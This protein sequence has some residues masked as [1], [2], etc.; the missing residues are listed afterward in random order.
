VSAATSPDMERHRGWLAD[1]LQRLDEADRSEC[2]SRLRTPEQY[3]QTTAELA[4][5][6]V[7][8]GAGL[9]V[10]QNPR[11]GHLTPDV[12]ATD[13][14]GNRI[15]FEVWTRTIPQETVVRLR[16]WGALAQV[17][18]KV[19]VPVLLA[20]DSD[21]RSASDPPL[22]GEVSVI[23]KSLGRWL[24]SGE[25]LAR[26]SLA[27]AG[28]IFTDYGRYDGDSAVLLPVTLATHAD[29]RHV[30][31]AVNN[32]VRRYRKLAME[33]SVPFVVVL[34]AEP[35]SGLDYD[36]VASALSGRNSLTLNFDVRTFGA[37]DSRPTELRQSDAP[38]KFD[39]CLS[40]VGW[41]ES[42]PVSE[43]RLTLWRAVEAQRPLP[44][45]RHSQVIFGSAA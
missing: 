31:D 18:A 29:S 10:Q 35:R 9:K 44:D 40:A 6:A 7:L 21:Q 16:Q 33:H 43:P 17:V 1:Q 28:Y 11:V 24:Q 41:L 37:M 22:P 13:S 4:L 45:I 5:G 39:P 19:K 36:L 15:I 27:V 8:L 42:P 34:S 23:A 25:S 38:P 12:E 2:L 20:V 32:K 14:A 3:I 26:G 30:W